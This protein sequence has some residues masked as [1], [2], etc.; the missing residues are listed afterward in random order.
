[1][2]ASETL[3]VY[4]IRPKIQE[5]GDFHPPTQEI[6]AARSK[7][8]AIRLFDRAE[9]DE[10]EIDDVNGIALAMSKPGVVFWRSDRWPWWT[11]SQLRGAKP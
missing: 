9:Y 1:M 8:E 4:A 6:V 2:S 10:I 3:K 5:M 11:E 7:G